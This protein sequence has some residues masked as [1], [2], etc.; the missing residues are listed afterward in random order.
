MTFQNVGLHPASFEERS[1][2]LGDI[3]V[4]PIRDARELTE[5]AQH[6]DAGPVGFD[7]PSERGILIEDDIDDRLVGDF[8]H[9]LGVLVLYLP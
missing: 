6:L 7:V 1:L 3:P 8:L 9:L 4:P 2:R 5:A